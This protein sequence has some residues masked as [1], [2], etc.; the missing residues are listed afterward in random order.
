MGRHGVYRIYFH[1][2]LSATIVEF[3]AK[4]DEW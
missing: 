3:E 4:G 1:V 2:Q